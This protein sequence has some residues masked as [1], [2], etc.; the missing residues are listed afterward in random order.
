MRGTVADGVVLM[1]ST[2]ITPAHA[3]NRHLSSFA[4]R[5]SWDHPRAC[6]EQQEEIEAIG[7]DEG[8][9]PRMRGTAFA[10]IAPLPHTGITPAHAGNRLKRSHIFGLSCLTL[11]RFHSVC[12]RPDICFRSPPVPYVRPCQLFQNAAAL[13]AA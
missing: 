4:P 7:E 9:P 8:S 6:G 10:C 12:N 5:I 11:Y 2:G 3:G 13:F 1:Q